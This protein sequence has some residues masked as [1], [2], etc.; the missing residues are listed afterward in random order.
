MAFALLDDISAGTTIPAAPRCTVTSATRRPPAHWD[1]TVLRAGGTVFHSSA[2]GAAALVRGEEPWYLH[3]HREGR[4]VALAVGAAIRSTP[5][6]WGRRQDELAFQT[7]PQLTRART[8]T[9]R[10]V[11]AAIRTFARA[12]GFGRISLSSYAD[13]QPD[14]TPT[15]EWDGLTLAPRLEFRVPLAA[16]PDASL[17]GMRSG[18]RQNIRRALRNG[19]EFVE[20]SSVTGAMALRE[21]QDVTYGRQ[22][23]RGNHDAH[24][25]AVE[26]Y[27]IVMSAYLAHRAI[28]FWFV[29][30]DGRPLSGAG[31]MIF[32][33]RAYYLLAGTSE[34]GYDCHAA[35]AMMGHLI[36]YLITHG[37]RELNFGGMAV[38]TE[39]EDHIEHGL[40]RFKT[41]FGANVIRCYTATGPT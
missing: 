2:M 25:W 11:V 40:Y 38:G 7:M 19:L 16:C 41:G 14:E 26:D 39:A 28:R 33:P 31:I 21:L 12:N 35:Y 18:H 17:D 4:T 20:D 24:A 5:R 36:P 30:R 23:R 6:F 9:R 37:V 27:R 22:S 32:G 1:R 8:E 13:V 3:L 10:D 34:E 29:M 15:L